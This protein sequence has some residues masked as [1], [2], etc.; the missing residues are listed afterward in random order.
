MT[1]SRGIEL[2]SSLNIRPAS[3]STGMLL[4]EEK[5]NSLDIASLLSMG[6]PVILHQTEASLENK[7]IKDINRDMKEN[8]QHGLEIRQ[9]TV[10]SVGSWSTRQ[11]PATSGSQRQRHLQFVGQIET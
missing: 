7:K 10:G 4:S 2:C 11:Q 3:F 8:G 1:F 6:I 9:L 5:F